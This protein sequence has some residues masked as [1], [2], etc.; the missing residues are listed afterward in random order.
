MSNETIEASYITQFSESVHVLAQQESARLGGYVKVGAM[1]GNEWAYDRLGSVEA[2]ELVSRFSTVV[3]DDIEHTRRKISKSRFAA[4]LWMDESDARSALND[5]TREYAPQCVKAMYRQFDRLLTSKMF[6]TVYTGRDMTTALTFAAGGGRTVNM[7]A[8]V[9]L[10]K[11]LEGIQNFIDDEII[12]ERK[13]KMCWGISGDEHTALLQISQLTSGDYS[14]QMAVEDGEIVKACG[15]ELVRFGAAAA[16]PVLGVSGG[17]RTSFLMAE[18]AMFVGI[19]KDISAKVKDRPDLHET[20]Q[21]EVLYELGAV[22]TEEP[23]IQ[24]V[25]TTD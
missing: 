22:R 19:S 2:R 1:K 18:G 20:T 5:P 24:K 8:G 4:V 13:Q 3:P 25:T 14:R 6:D 12:N 11:I 17:V 23:R 16:R 7:T 21:V 9:T 10:A 15:I